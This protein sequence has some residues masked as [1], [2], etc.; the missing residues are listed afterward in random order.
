MQVVPWLGVLPVA[1]ET[2]FPSFADHKFLEDVLLPEDDS[3]SCSG[4]WS[5]LQMLFNFTLAHSPRGSGPFGINSRLLE[6]LCFKIALPLARS[7]LHPIMYADGALKFENLDLLTSEK[8]MDFGDHWC[9][10]GLVS[11]LSLCAAVR[12]QS[13]DM[14]PATEWFEEVKWDQ[15]LNFWPGLLPND[16]N[17]HLSCQAYLEAILALST[18]PYCGPCLEEHKWFVSI[19]EI[20]DNVVRWLTSLWHRGAYIF[21]PRWQGPFAAARVLPAIEFKASG[22]FAGRQLGAP[23]DGT[24]ASELLR[25]LAA[26]WGPQ[27]FEN[28]SERQKHFEKIFGGLGDLPVIK[29]R[30][31]RGVEVKTHPD[32]FRGR[33]SH[34]RFYIYDLPRIVHG[35]ILEELHGPVREKER[36]PP[37][38]NLGLS[39]CTETHNTK[40]VFNSFRPFVAETTFL[41]K[42]LA[43]PDEI[44]VANPDDASYFV[45]PFLSSTW[46]TM[47]APFCWVRCSAH[48][49]LNALLPFLTFYNATTAHRHLFL[50]TDSVGDLP[51]DL[52]MQPLVLHYG[53]SPCR[54]SM[55]TFTTLGPLIAPPS[56]TDDLPPLGRWEFTSKDLFL[57]LADGLSNRPFRKE[58]FQELDKWQRRLPHLFAVSRRDEKIEKQ[59][60]KEEEKRNCPTD[61]ILPAEVLWAEQMRRALFCPVMP[62]DNTFRMRLFHAVLVGCIPV[63]ILFPGGSWYRNQGPPVNSSFPFPERIAWRNLSVELPFDPRI[64]S[65]S[66]WAKQ[67][68]PELLRINVH[69]LFH[70]QHL[71]LWTFMAA[72]LGLWVY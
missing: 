6:S 56:I 68:V 48:R 47:T 70:K 8:Y 23:Q 36:R 59:S 38:C 65:I 33:R 71:G 62:G 9:P 11:A 72:T 53:P 7:V 22:A 43:G 37:I 15:L 42:L 19:E 49:P 35:R 64:Q 29:A 16:C 41:A 58:V 57:F 61:P 66:D 21:P 32:D 30:G 63:V 44:I 14:S 46:C 39:P 24:G 34:L 18:L 10:P 3:C 60:C 55:S 51:Q 26:A 52:Q 4:P 40:G 2:G 28:I 5:N 69:D 1:S 67:M 17:R 20:N 50:G 31:M 12:V 45:V 27:S 25:S 13:E 54:E